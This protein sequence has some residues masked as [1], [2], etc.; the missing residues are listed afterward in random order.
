MFSVAY[1]L[2][3]WIFIYLTTNTKFS[4]TL[5]VCLPTAAEWTIEWFLHQ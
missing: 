1:E 2:Y 3:N 4:L 5:I